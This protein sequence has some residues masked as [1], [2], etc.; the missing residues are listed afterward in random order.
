MIEIIFTRPLTI[1]NSLEPIN[2]ALFSRAKPL[3][4][5]RLAKLLSFSFDWKRCNTS[6]GLRAPLGFLAFARKMIPFFRFSLTFTFFFSLSTLC[7]RVFNKTIILLG[8][9]GYEMIITNSVLRAPRWLYIISY[10]S[11]P[12]RIIVIHLF[13]KTLSE[14]TANGSCRT[15]IARPKGTVVSI[16][17]SSSCG[18]KLG[19]LSN[20]DDDS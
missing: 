18:A 11:R 4:S 20:Q 16:L 13:Q 19:S 15:E 10:P 14:R 5:P 3:R 12:R 2:S 1:Y 7:R 9:A 8:L 17:M 6:K